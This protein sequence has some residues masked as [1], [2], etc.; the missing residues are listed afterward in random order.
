MKLNPI[1]RVLVEVHNFTID[2]AKFWI[3][4]NMDFSFAKKFKVVSPNGEFI[5]GRNVTKFAK[6]HGLDPA[7]FSRVV[8]GLR[9]TC[10]GWRLA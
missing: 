8:N 9:K 4:C 7:G 3:S 10:K 5:E 6:D 2:V 1:E